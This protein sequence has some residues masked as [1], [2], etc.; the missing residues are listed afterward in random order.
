M[1]VMI[2]IVNTHSQRVAPAD[3]CT[4]ATRGQYNTD[5]MHKEQG[6]NKLTQ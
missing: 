2:S 5:M 3:E 4:L 1:Y 6:H